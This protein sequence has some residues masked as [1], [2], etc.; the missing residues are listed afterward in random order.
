M[1][2][3]DYLQPRRRYER[4]LMVGM[5]GIGV[6]FLLAAAIK[7][8]THD[9]L[10]THRAGFALITVGIHEKQTSDGKPVRAC[11]DICLK[12]GELR[13]VACIPKALERGQ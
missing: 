8:Q 13:P 12:H 9:W 5:L 10:S 2:Y 4:W 11:F 7:S 1:R 6:G 3:I